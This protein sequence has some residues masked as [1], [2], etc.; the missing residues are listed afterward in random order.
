MRDIAEWLECMTANA[1][2]QQSWIQFQQSP[3][4]IGIWEA[5]DEAVLNKVREKNFWYFGFTS[6]YVYVVLH[7]IPTEDLLP[8]RTHTRSLNEDKA[9]WT[10][11]K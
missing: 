2:V 3:N 7:Y 10:L 4:P 9:F 5:A 8:Q 6:F 11:E 1:K